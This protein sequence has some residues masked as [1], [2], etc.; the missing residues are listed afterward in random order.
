MPGG[1]RLAVAWYCCRLL[2]MSSRGEGLGANGTGIVDP[3]S[4]KAYVQGVGLG[5]SGGKLGD[6]V[7]EANRNTKGGYGVFLE[8][9]KERA[10]ERFEQM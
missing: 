7:D 1:R 10:K 6:A 4:T 5:A 3:I 9:T 8:R 2:G